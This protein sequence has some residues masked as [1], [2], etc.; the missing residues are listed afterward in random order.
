MT[1]IVRGVETFGRYITPMVASR[2]EEL[3]GGGKSILYSELIDT[4][5]SVQENS[6]SYTDADGKKH[7][8]PE[9]VAARAKISG[10][11]HPLSKELRD[12]VTNPM[13]PDHKRRIKIF[14]AKANLKKTTTRLLK[15]LERLER[16]NKFTASLSYNQTLTRIRNAER[17]ID[18]IKEELEL[19]SD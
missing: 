6:M 19:L 4:N 15:L 11:G 16:I 12:A 9:E 13:S 1:K 18:K 17:R 14:N 5:T 3:R 8:T 2:L 7:F 10:L